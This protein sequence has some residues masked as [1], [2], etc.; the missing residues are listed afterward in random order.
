MCT[1]T[2]CNDSNHVPPFK[3][4][5]T[6]Y[7]DAKHTRVNPGCGS[8]KEL[9]A[10]KQIRKWWWKKNND[11]WTCV[12]SGHT[13]YMLSFKRHCKPQQ[14]VGLLQMTVKSMQLCSLSMFFLCSLI[15]ADT[16]SHS[17][18]VATYSQQL[19]ASRF[20]G[21]IFVNIKPHRRE[22]DIYSGL[23]EIRKEIVNANVGHK[24]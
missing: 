15:Y 9:S 10:F 18:C 19:L 14:S 1:V 22:T 3:G 23:S 6:D 12:A 4:C 2:L 11:C 20:G 21:N 5:M 8:G 24:K 16:A 7:S 17:T 13:V